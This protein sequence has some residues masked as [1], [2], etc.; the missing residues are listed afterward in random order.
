MT[1]IT[2]DGRITK[3]D[4]L[5]TDDARV[6][7]LLDSEP[8]EA[9]PAVVE[10]ALVV[11]A[12]GL[13]TMGLD[14]GLD[15]VRDQIRRDAEHATAVAEDRIK[16]MLAAAEQAFTA[17]L[18]PNHR[19]SLL[20][21]SLREFHQWRTEFLQ[22]LDSDTAGTVTGKLLERLE[23]FVGADGILEHQLTAALDTGTDTSS[24]GR[25]RAEILGE[26]HSLRDAVHHQH[27]RAVESEKGT[28]KGFTFED[29]IEARVRRWAAGVGGCLVERTSRDG[30]ALGPHAL[31]G[32][33]VVELPGG[34]RVVLEMKN[35]QRVT[36]GG[37]GG[38]LEELDRG[39]ANRNAEAAICVSARDAFPAE[40]G[41]FAIY[42]NR[43]LLVDDGADS[44]LDA[45]LRIAQLLGEAAANDRDAP[46]DRAA[47]AVQLER[48]RSLATRFSSSKRALT[49]AQAAIDTVKRSLDGIRSDLLELVDGVATS[50]G[51]A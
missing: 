24:L 5:V 18:D 37:P 12:H 3:V 40:A 26:I 43:I 10:R 19:S 21:R 31:V 20:S 48:V 4:G 47:I 7:Q 8:R 1:H 29:Q 44:L 6:A 49:D 17:Q 46:I 14:V 16:S 25:L 34:F 41:L 27:G 22:G 30:G 32:D 13:V 23:G 38:I 42:G 2:S 36:L 9:W 45:G 11:G 33:V 50:V 39:M 35:T 28:Q 51:G 15:T